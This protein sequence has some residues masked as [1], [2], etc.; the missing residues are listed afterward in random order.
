MLT[1]VRERRLRDFLDWA[2]VGRYIGLMDSPAQWLNRKRQFSTDDGMRFMKIDG[3]VVIVMKTIRIIMIWT[4]IMNVI[5]LL[6]TDR[7]GV[8]RQNLDIFQAFRLYVINWNRFFF[9]ISLIPIMKT[10]RR[11]KTPYYS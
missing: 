6:H 5:T 7:R 11:R 3:S 10:A 2:N 8:A 1:E 9:L 4:S